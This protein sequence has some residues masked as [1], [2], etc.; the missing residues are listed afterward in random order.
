LTKPGTL[1]AAQPQARSAYVTITL[2]GLPFQASSTARSQGCKRCRRTPH[3]P[4]LSMEDSVWAFPI[5]LA[6]TNG[7]SID[8]SSSWY[9]DVSFPRVC[10]PFGAPRRLAAISVGYTPFGNPRIKGCLLLPEAFRSLPRPSSLSQAKSS[11]IRR[12]CVQMRICI[13]A[14]ACANPMHGFNRGPLPLALHML[15]CRQDVAS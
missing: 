2:Y 7:I 10:A 9:S 5:S 4:H 13:P 15:S 3:L 8:F 14:D 6:A 12:R 1:S 11:T